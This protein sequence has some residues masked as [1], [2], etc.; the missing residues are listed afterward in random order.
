MFKSWLLRFHRWITLFF[1]VP[2]LIVVATGLVLSIEPLM[3][4]SA[5]EKPL[6]KADLLGYLAKHDPQGKATGLAIRSYENSLTIDGAGE[7]GETEIDLTSGEVMAEEAGFSW[8]EFL[9]KT[10]RLH[11]SLL[12]DMAW[13][14]TASTFAMMALI[15]LGILMGLPRLKN[16]IGGWHN[17]AAWITLPMVILSPL[18][19]LL[20]VYGINFLTPPVGARPEPISIRE[21]VE[22]LGDKVDFA[23]MT[24]LR[25]RGSRGMLAR[26][27]VEDGLANYS[28]QKTGLTLLPTNWP[29]AIH[30]GTWSRSL[31]PS[32]NILVSVVFIGLWFTGMFIWVRRTFLRKRNRGREKDASLQAAQ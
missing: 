29:R 9:R 2:L 22:V 6:T 27:F 21:A 32:L 26:V 20:M 16:T 12:M 23:G 24:S 3:Q 17:L 13:V 19:G 10:R 5:L 30:E 4:Q 31:A 11:D 1:A 7:D 25:P 15:V 14:V 18:T 8:S 28:V